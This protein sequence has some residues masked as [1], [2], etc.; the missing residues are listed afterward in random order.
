MKNS[1]TIIKADL[2]KSVAQAA[3]L[4]LDIYVNQKGNS[5]RKAIKQLRVDIQE[6]EF[7]ITE[8]DLQDA[9]A[10]HNILNEYAS[11]K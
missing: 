3:E 6:F 2:N 9:C 10:F 11:V 1:F 7:D 5:V 8:A 4:L